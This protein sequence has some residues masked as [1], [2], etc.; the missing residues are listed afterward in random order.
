MR[1]FVIL[2]GG[3]IL[4]FLG[5]SLS[6]FAIGVWIFQQTGSVM[7]F[8]LIGLFTLAPVVLIAP[9]AG[10]VA[11]RWD[12]KV[13]MIVTDRYLCPLF[14]MDILASLDKPA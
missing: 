11:D 6:G 3:Q 7:D 4:S 5:T 8:A 10:V 12:K 2:Y 9:L 13:M 1:N 14:S